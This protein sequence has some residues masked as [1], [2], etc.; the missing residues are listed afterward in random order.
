MA[1]E[2]KLTVHGWKEI[3]AYVGR[4]VRTVQRW[5]RQRGLPV[6]RLAG[7]DKGN[8]YAVIS[9]L[10]EWLHPTKRESAAAEAADTPLTP[11][12][13]PVTS[14]VTSIVTT[15]PWPWHSRGAVAL[16]A[17]ALIALLSFSFAFYA[18]RE[19]SKRGSKRLA[20]RQQ[21]P[22]RQPAQDALYLQGMYQLD[23][24]TP[25]SLLAAKGAFLELT[26][27]NPNDAA[28]WSAL[29][30]TFALLYSYG[31]QVD[32]GVQPWAVAAACRA[33][34]LDPRL[35]EPHAVLGFADFFWAGRVREAES[36]FQNALRLDPASVTTRNWYGLILTYETRYPEA[37]EQL[38]QAQQLEPSSTA[39]LSTRALALG[40]SG[41]REQ[42]F[43]LLKQTA[44][45][46]QIPST[47]F[48]IAALSRLS[49]RD[50]ALLAEEELKLA[51][52]THADDRI[53]VWTTA[54]AAYR[55]GGEP[56]M[57]RS[58][59]ASSRTNGVSAT[60]LAEAYA[61]LGEFDTA[62]QVLGKAS[63]RSPLLLDVAMD[64]L[65]QSLH[66]D[67]RFRRILLDSGLPPIT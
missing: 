60:Q 20:A 16:G 21:A 39:I 63:Q 67:P 61:A 19:Q 34:A 44:G 13:A 52:D 50:P 33:S 6:R 35:A 53:R 10:D 8:V 3:A 56:A 65:F 23:K 7:A 30:Q 29:A 9:E 47:R 51:A 36:E 32:A 15:R 17:A 43:R 11:Q 54:Q 42:A 22:S 27:K 26:A 46:D 14:P 55:R 12:P 18:K 2:R 28:S 31:V 24:R 4:E 49:P 64:P 57:W 41:H 37:L 40:L 62:V 58:I 48:V 5:E 66:S 38:A 25:E 1:D 59:I 45:K